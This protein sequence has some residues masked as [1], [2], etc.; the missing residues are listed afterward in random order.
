MK[1][2]FQSPL[3]LLCLLLMLAAC[4]DAPSHYADSGSSN[5][6]YTA[7]ASA[8]D[9]I[10]SVSIDVSALE[11]PP[12]EKLLFDGRFTGTANG[13]SFRL[14]LT[15]EAGEVKGSM[16]QKDESFLLSGR[17]SGETFT[18]VMK[19]ILGDL[20]FEAYYYGDNLVLQL[21]KETMNNLKALVVL[22]EE[23]AAAL[24]A[25]DKIVFMPE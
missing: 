10:N 13:Q 18:G 5:T 9:T 6:S 1:R 7:P 24:F 2:H 15:N 11:P 12:A 14:S 16:S 19:Y 25:D 17:V 22:V 3:G 20:P 21:D 23:D 8:S 4:N